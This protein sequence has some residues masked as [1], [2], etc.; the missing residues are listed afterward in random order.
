MTR[1]VVFLSDFGY[2]NEWVGICHAVVNRIAPQSHIVDLSHG[3]PPLVPVAEIGEK[4]D[5][6]RHDSTQASCLRLLDASSRLAG[7]RPRQ[8]SPRRRT[9]VPAIMSCSACFRAVNAT[10]R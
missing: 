4:H 7:E 2:R 3:I 9:S 10:I 8:Y 1:P 6:T 5:W